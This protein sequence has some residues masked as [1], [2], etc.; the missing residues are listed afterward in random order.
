MPS[1]ADWLALQAAGP[2][3][4]QKANARASQYLRAA[5]IQMEALTGSAEWDQYRT[6]LEAHRKEAVEAANI[7]QELLPKTYDDAAARKTQC[8]YYYQL[9]RAHA[10]RFAVEFPLE[11]MKAHKEGQGPLPAPPEDEQEPGATATDA[12]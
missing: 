6:K 4:E 2:I 3:I 12:G 11:L 5:A 8:Q 9:G 7:A 10:F 1:K